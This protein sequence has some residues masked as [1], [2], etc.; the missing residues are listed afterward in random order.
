MKL[1]SIYEVIVKEGVKADPRGEAKVKEK[2]K[3]NKRKFNELKKEE[4]EKFDKE[5]LK[6]PYADTRIL[7]GNE[8]KEV[9]GIL[10]GIDIGVEELLLADRLEQMGKIIDLVISHHPAGRA[11]AS[12]YKVMEMQV[13]ILAKFGVSESQ[14]ENLLQER[15][16]EVSR[17]ILPANHTRASDAAKLLE[18]PFMCCHTPADNHVV[19]FLQKIFD[20]KKPDTLAD[21]INILE[22]IPEYKHAS[23]N[24]AGP[25]IFNGRKESRCGKI[26]V[27]MTGGTEGSKEI[28]EKIAN[29][30]IG[31]IVCMHLSEEHLKKVKKAKVN[32]VI[33][34]HM[35]SDSLGVNL[36]LDKIQKKEELKIIPCSGFIRIKR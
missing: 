7:Y 4:K 20:N 14:A 23:K 36:I 5:S 26:F 33:A 1:K 10:M 16:E 24:N 18:I 34:G 19:E 31:T 3:N 28:F 32:A 15:I 30:G 11:Y 35:A 27:D 6:N 17:K 2:L 25:R 8:S 29:A 12:F 22:D 13:D 9:K 21:L